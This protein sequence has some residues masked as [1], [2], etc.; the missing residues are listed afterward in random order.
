MTLAASKQTYF[1]V[2]PPI[3]LKESNEQEILSTEQMIQ[4]LHHA[5]QFEDIA[6]GKNR[7]IV[8]GQLDKVVQHFVY[9]ASIKHGFSEAEA[10]ESKGKIYTFGSYR[11]GVH[12]AGADI[13]TLCVVPAHVSREY[14]FE[15]MTDLLSKRPDVKELT[16]VPEAYVPVIKMEFGNVPIDLTF[17][18]LHLPTIPDSLEL[19]DTKILRNL[20]EQC[21]RSINGS[22]VTDEILRLVPNIKTFRESLRCIK[23]WAKRRGIYSN[24]LGFLGGVAW[25]MLVARV[26]QLYPN[27]VAGAIIVRFF[28]IMY[29]WNWPQPILLKPIED[30][31]LRVKVWNPKIY[32]Q[33]RAHRMPI[34]T[35]AYPSMCATHNVS[36]STLT[37]M[38][39]EFKRGADIL[40]HIAS[41]SCTWAD[42]FT[43]NDFFYRYKHY[44]Q[45]EVSSS[46]L[47]SHHKTTGLIESRLRHLVM[48]LENI[49]HVVLAH[50]HIDNFDQAY[51]C[52]NADIALQ[53]ANGNMPNAQLSND[54]IMVSS[55]PYSSN[56]SLPDDHES[57]LYKLYSTVFFVGLLISKKPSGFV[58]NRRID[59]S[60]P[61]QEFLML[62][63]QTE[64]WNPENMFINIRFFKNLE[65]PVYVFKSGV[66]PFIQTHDP[67]KLNKQLPTNH[68]S[69]NEPSNPSSGKKTRISDTLDKSSITTP[70]L[71]TNQI[72]NKPHLNIDKKNIALVDL[73]ASNTDSLKKPKSN[74]LST[75][76]DQQK[77]VRTFELPN[78]TE[79]K[80]LIVNS[81]LKDLGTILPSDNFGVNASLNP[82][83]KNE[84]KNVSNSNT[85]AFLPQIKNIRIPNAPPQPPP[86][87]I[88]LRL[89]DPQYHI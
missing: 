17:A 33:D 45:V 80:P 27:A 2:T 7:E 24:S 16:P 58:G 13:D 21:I 4:A 56:Q 69:D 9:L 89:A 75:E 46:N 84:S 61:A 62:I 14:F 43:E 25:A 5:G 77:Q 49:E 78:L 53:I 42:L 15:I 85:E 31:P 81:N 52:K 19:L 70:V 36:K 3:S 67:L 68:S 32:I 34:I 44:L 50:P 39:A 41:N 57:T 74:S 73:P 8:L 38:T 6:A 47:D 29:Q 51:T 86:G 66:N 1:G 72:S 23:Y 40:D 60:W 12:G 88:K 10:R 82:S 63:K 37:I 71:I 79:D 28:K 26:C 18:S 22:R 35:P 55:L 65:L 64:M 30:G 48:K 54:P 87:G 20:D 11:L 59:L 76:N 83:L